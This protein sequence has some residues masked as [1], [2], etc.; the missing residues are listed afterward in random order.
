MNGNSNTGK[1]AL[2]TGATRGIGLHTVRQLAEQGV[3]VLLAG[4]DRDRADAAARELRGEG[5]SVEPIALD[6]TDGASIEA[7]AREVDARHGRLDIL[8]NNAGIILD[9]GSLPPSQQ[10]LDTW[11]R[12]FDTNLFGLVAVTQAFLPLLREAASGRIVNVSSILGSLTLH[13]QPG[14][15]VYDFKVPAYNVS[16]SAVNAWT[17]QLAW[18][19][20]DTPIKVNT[21]HPGYVRT[22]MNNSGGEQRGEI[23]ADEGARTSVQMALIDADG[24][25]GS[26]TYLGETLPW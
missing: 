3:H 25:T 14:S 22:D 26:F 9:D 12:T 4:R 1:I 19:L 24:P 17:V 2:V 7:A 8:V 13:G 11:R 18:E 5:L 16:K 23:E 21:V 6:V 15:P 10:S 20:R